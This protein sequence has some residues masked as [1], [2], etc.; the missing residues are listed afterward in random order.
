MLEWLRFVLGGCV[1]KGTQDSDRIVALN[2][3]GESLEE[4]GTHAVDIIII[5]ILTKTTTQSEMKAVF[6]AVAWLTK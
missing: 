4:K 6:T 1:G 2:W 3:N 5:I